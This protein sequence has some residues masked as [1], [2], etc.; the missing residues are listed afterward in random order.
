MSCCGKKREALQQHRRISVQPIPA[1]PAP[2][3]PCTPITF[4]G[5]GDYLVTGQHSGKVY[6]F[7]SNQPEQWIDPQD[8][9]ALLATGLFQ[10][11]S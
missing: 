7:S 6:H 4:K 5:M 3:P 11:K 9:A 8:T 2:V 1:P 10:T